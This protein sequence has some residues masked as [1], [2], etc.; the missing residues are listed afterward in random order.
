MIPRAGQALA[1]IAS[2][3]ASSV[4]PTIPSRYHAADAGMV[5]MLLLALA[6]DCER[7]IAN[8][9]ADA[10]TLRELFAAAPGAPGEA[11][12]AAFVDSAPGSLVR[13]AVVA[14]HDRGMRALIALH[15][16]AEVHDPELDRRIWDFLRAHTER[17]RFD[18]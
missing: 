4:V 1:D 8:C 11:E 12:R 10:E 17:N 7:A 16:W 6:R 15:A 18:P 3:L 13:E 14:W 2:K 5:A 9:F